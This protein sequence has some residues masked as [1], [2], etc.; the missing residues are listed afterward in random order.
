M[1]AIF[2]TCRRPTL[3]PEDSSGHRDFFTQRKWFF[4]PPFQR[5]C[6]LILC[7]KSMSF[8]VPCLENGCLAKQL[9][10]MASFLDGSV[11]DRLRYKSWRIVPRPQTLMFSSALDM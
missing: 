8:L 5:I 1:V 10:L 6:G 7:N 4:S 2:A 3:L 11:I 9:S